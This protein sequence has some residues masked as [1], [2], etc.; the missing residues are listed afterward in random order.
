MT[1]DHTAQRLLAFWTIFSALGLLL[2]VGFASAGDVPFSDVSGEL[3]VGVESEDKGDQ[4]LKTLAAEAQE[5]AALV[6]SAAILAAFVGVLSA[7]LVTLILFFAF[8][9]RKQ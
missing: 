4:G 5:E 6:L 2:V 8:Y 9:W 3:G 7:L 1:V